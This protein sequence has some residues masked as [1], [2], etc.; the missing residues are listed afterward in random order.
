M[1][2]KV[3]V[4]AGQSQFPEGS[5][6]SIAC[7]VD[8]YPIPR[9]LWYKDD[10]LI[11]T[12]NRIKIS[13]KAISNNAVLKKTQMSFCKYYR[14]NFPY[15]SAY[16][17]DNKLNANINQILFFLELNRLIISDANQEDSGR[18]RCEAVNDLSTDS[19]SVDIRV[20]GERL[21]YTSF[22]IHIFLNTI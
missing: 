16:F 8:G 12:N 7:T 17:H 3:N 19:D 14:L 22:F 15:I 20:A 13:G 2:V 6:I 21:R 9:V 10:E 1:P 4:S 18:Y 5:D 11:R